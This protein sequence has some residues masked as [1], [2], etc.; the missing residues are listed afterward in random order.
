MNSYA[1]YQIVPFPMTLNEPRFQGHDII[2]RQKRSNNSQMV[3]DRAIVAM[4]D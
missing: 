4:A 1:I 3:Q 2:Q